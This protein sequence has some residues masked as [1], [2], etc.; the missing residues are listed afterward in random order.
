MDLELKGRIAVVT[1]ASAG[2]GRGIARVLAKE[3]AQTVIVSRRIA[4]LEALAGEIERDG[5]ARPLVVADDLQN[6]DAPARI[7]RQVFARFDRV[8]I[9]VNNAGGSRPL[10][11]CAADEAW[12]EA[13]AI[14]FTAV[15]KVTQAFLPAMQRN[16]WGRIINITGSLEPRAV[17]GANAAKA[18]VHIWAKGLSCDV[19]KDGITVNCLMPGRIHSEQIDQR[20]HPS[21][22]NQRAFAEA[23]IPAGYF[24]DPED[25]AHAVAF[26]C[27]PKAR[28]ITGQRMYIDG[29]MHRSI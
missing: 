26:L 25:I 21:A 23:N 3:G 22:E 4:L 19:A 6:R 16:R 2:I 28:Y 9:L 8:D 13:F 15:R 12:D 20:M 5:E 24:G 18:G 1:G 7:A 29:G 17:N 14:N 11:V 10:P 27:S